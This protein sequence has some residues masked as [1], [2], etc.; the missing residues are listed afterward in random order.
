MPVEA[1]ALLPAMEAPQLRQEWGRDQICQDPSQQLACRGFCCYQIV[2]I[3]INA[4][5]LQFYASAKV[6]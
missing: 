1:S 6:L 3:S 2:D 4:A 5:S